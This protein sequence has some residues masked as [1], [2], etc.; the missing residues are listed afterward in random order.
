MVP[1]WAESAPDD[2]NVI[3][4]RVQEIRF[5]RLMKFRGRAKGRR[6]PRSV[7][8]LVK[9]ALFAM[10]LDPFNYE[11]VFATATLERK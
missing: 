5:P 10:I 9:V 7:R 3:F 4:A 11:E 8:V 6:N 1:R 2:L